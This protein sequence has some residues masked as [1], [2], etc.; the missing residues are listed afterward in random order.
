METTTIIGIVIAVGII[1]FALYILLRKPREF[2]PSLDAE[3]HINPETNQPVLPRFVRQQL[4]MIEFGQTPE[5]K[6]AKVVKEKAT[7]QKVETTAETKDTQTSAEEPNKKLEDVT[8]N[9]DVKAP[10]LK[11]VASSVEDKKET[12]AQK[13][14][15]VQPATAAVEKQS[16]EKPKKEAIYHLNK[17]IEKAEI[18]E[19][20]EESSILDMHLN[21]QQRYDD[22]CSL[23]N[24][25]HIISLNVYPGPRCILS[26]DKTLKILL[27]YGL[28]F[29]ELSCFHRYKNLDETQDDQ[30]KAAPLMFS[31]LK[32]SDEGPVGFDLET[33][34]TEQVHGLAFFLA[35]PNAYAQE[36]FDTMASTAGLIAREIDGKVFDENNDELSMQLK[37]YWRRQVIDFKPTA[38]A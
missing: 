10:E 9:A 1:I 32:I 21:E 29:G 6:S 30:A 20:D 8:Q 26:G 28:R 14:D 36:G 12:D 24:A 31:V 22:E 19:F 16:E 3:L 34:S 5:K 33:L 2:V 15:L 35:L 11:D 17:D 13:A 37:E 25:Q 4:N 23:A 7:E 27:K 38:S 18:K